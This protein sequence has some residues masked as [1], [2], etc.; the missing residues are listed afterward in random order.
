MTWLTTI[1]GGLFTYL[2]FPVIV[3]GTFLALAG[4]PVVTLVFLHVMAAELLAD[5]GS[6]TAAL[7]APTQI[8]YGALVGL[9]LA[10]SVHW[11]KNLSGLMPLYALGLSSLAMFMVFLFMKGL[12]TSVAFLLLGAL[13][14]PALYIALFRGLPKKDRLT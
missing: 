9:A 14:V 6:S 2:L 13:V 12:L 11:L 7:S 8:L 3:L 5:F 4:G 10:E 1:L